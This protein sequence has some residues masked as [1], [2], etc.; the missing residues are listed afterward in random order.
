VR[1]IDSR[2]C[3]ENPFRPLRLQRATDTNAIYI[4]TTTSVSDNILYV[5]V[6]FFFL[7]IY[8]ASDLFST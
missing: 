1:T 5:Y 2:R 4:Y 6:S 8:A 3:V 7:I